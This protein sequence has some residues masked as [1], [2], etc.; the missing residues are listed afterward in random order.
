M[1]NA[2]GL[3]VSYGTVR[4]LW[5]AS[6]SVADGNVV[7]LIGANGAGK[8]TLLKA[9]MGV[10]RPEAGRVEFD[11][12]RIDGMEPH[13][14]V[15]AGIGYVPEGRRLFPDLTVVET[16]LLGAYV[17]RA[18]TRIEDSMNYVYTVFPTLKEKRTQLAGT[19]SGGEQQMLAISRAL[20][21]RPKLL[22][23]DEPSLGLAPLIFAKVIDALREINQTGVSILLAEQNAVEA[24]NLATDGYVVE[25]GRIGLSGPASNLLVDERV[26][27]AYLGA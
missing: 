16:L 8:S 7:A 9:I 26:K 17:R 4:V 24:L 1:L 2:E 20:M 18:R 27:A 6:I 15:E 19:L 14:I 10:I 11:R 5:S 13:E 22:I 25:T 12:E 3:T 21:S 23:L